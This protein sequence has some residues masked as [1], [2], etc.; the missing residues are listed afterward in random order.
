MGSLFSKGH[1]VLVSVPR[2]LLLVCGHTLE[3]QQAACQRMEQL[4]R[5]EPV[6]CCWLDGFAPCIQL[7]L[8]Y[9]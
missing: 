7:A 8:Y 3:L 9:F 5:R 6:S 1:A 4:M 2:P